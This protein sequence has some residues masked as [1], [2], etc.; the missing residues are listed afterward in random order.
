MRSRRHFVLGAG[1]VAAAA[2][3][4]GCSVVRT[5][6]VKA[7]FL[8]EPAMP[9]PVAKPQPGVIRMGTVN[10]AAPFRGRSLVTRE[11]ELKYDSDYYNEF[12]A[13]PGNII[14]DAT[15]R[16]L[17]AARV[18]GTVLPMAVPTESD[19]LLEGFV[20]SIY[21]DARVSAQPVAVLQ[22]TYYLSK[23][24][25]GTG[26]PF[27]SKG[28]ERRIPFESGSV[29]KYV[30]ALNTALGEILAELCRDLAALTLPALP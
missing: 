20:G 2:L 28:Y 3:V 13:A 6:P 15:V 30:A 29:S 5:A 27:W 19:W 22:I 18:F 11:A 12:L 14:G 8:L 23:A 7:T 4:G 16:A 9:P 26:T 10:V 21:G 24:S 17:G 25:S 1:A